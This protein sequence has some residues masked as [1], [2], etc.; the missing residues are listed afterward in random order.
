M[1]LGTIG[2]FIAMISFAVML[3]TPKK[4]L[5]ISALVGTASGFIYLLSIHLGFGAV[6]SSFFSALS[7]AFISH[8]CARVFKAPVT[9]FLLGGILP[10][11]PGG[12]MYRIAAGVLDNN[13]TMVFDSFIKVLEIAGVIALAIFIMDVIFRIKR[14]EKRKTISEM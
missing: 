11:V 2:I 12:G 6:M 13:P 8:I 14:P 1:V 9:L 10:T 4:H 5:L 7:A 3:E